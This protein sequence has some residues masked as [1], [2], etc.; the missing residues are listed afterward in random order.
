[1]SVSTLRLIF[2]LLSVYW[3][4]PCRII[5]HYKVRTQVGRRRSPRDGA[6]V[7]SLQTF[8]WNLITDVQWTGTER[9]FERFWVIMD[10]FRFRGLLIII[11]IVFS[12]HQRQG[13]SCR[14][15]RSVS[16][17]RMEYICRMFHFLRTREVVS[18]WA[19][20]FILCNDVFE[21]KIWSLLLFLTS[22]WRR[23]FVPI[24]RTE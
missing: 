11:E 16:R 1:M 19:W 2:N 15:N 23:S 24:L 4:N 7:Y 3:R 21:R 20:F 22:T 18:V 10:S 14:F 6:T 13:G 9:I 17:M 5:L 12:R 8:Y